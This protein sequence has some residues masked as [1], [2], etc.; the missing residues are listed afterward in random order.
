M[1][2]LDV[3]NYLHAHIPLSRAMAVEVQTAL[4]T[5]VRLSAPLAP[6]INHRA[7]AF[8]GSACA[9]AILAAWTLL[10]VRLESDKIA[11]RVVIQKNTMY[12]E[13]P[14]T[15]A[16]VAEATANQPEVWARFIATLQRRKRA[17]IAVNVILRCKDEK[18]GALEGDFVAI[19]NG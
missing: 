11:A 9:L 18:V 10:Y 3:E 19:A 14:I 16:F 2:R 15:D 1:D 13:V 8:G 4:P 7:T 17:R 6:N 5:C 12:Y